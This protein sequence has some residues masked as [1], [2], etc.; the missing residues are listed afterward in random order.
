MFEHG[1][2]ILPETLHFLLFLLCSF[3]LY[4][5]ANDFREG[6]LSILTPVCRTNRVAHSRSRSWFL[7]VT[8]WFSLDASFYL[9]CWIKALPYRNRLCVCVCFAFGKIVSIFRKYLSTTIL[10]VY[11]FSIRLYSYPISPLLRFASKFFLYKT[12][13]F[14]FFFFYVFFFS[15]KTR[16]KPSQPIEATKIRIF[17]NS[18]LRSSKISPIKRWNFETHILI[19]TSTTRT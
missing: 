12:I 7:T 3:N 14:F 15:Q 9:A 10:S 16:M 13:F 5:I 6:Y 17:T 11:L 8:N 19:L 1:V 4:P 18:L 2:D